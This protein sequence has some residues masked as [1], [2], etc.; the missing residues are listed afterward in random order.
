MQETQGI[1]YALARRGRKEP[2]RA[3]L[4]ELVN[5]VAD[6][7]PGTQIAA[8]KLKHFLPKLSSA[9]VK[10]LGRIAGL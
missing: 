9:G 10:T 3:Q 1:A 4:P 6:E 7:A 8:L 5:A 2:D